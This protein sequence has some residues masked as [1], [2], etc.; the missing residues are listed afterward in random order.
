MR[1]W[2]RAHGPRLVLLG[3]LGLAIGLRFYRLGAQSLWNDE[4]T[5]VAL[6]Q[7]DL[8]TIALHAS[9]DIHPPLYYVLL[10]GWI[11]LVGT[12]EFAVRAL[13]ALA[14]VAVVGATYLYVRRRRPSDQGAALAAA[15]LAAVSPFQVYYA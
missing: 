6:A 1:A 8:P 13:S 4:G 15:L 2:C 5:S 3:I 9:Q 7:R 14:G 11:G 10:H 12:S